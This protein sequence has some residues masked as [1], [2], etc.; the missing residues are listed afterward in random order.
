MIA[1]VLNSSADTKGERSKHK[2][3]ENNPQHTVLTYSLNLHPQLVSSRNLWDA[4]SHPGMGWEGNL[5]L[6]PG[7][8][9]YP[10]Q[11]YMIKLKG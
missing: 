9:S 1:P 5:S 6:R 7:D 4:Q 2:T 3:G 11:S 10:P 8:D